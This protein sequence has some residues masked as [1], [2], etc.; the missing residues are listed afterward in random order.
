MVIFFRYWNELDSNRKRDN[1]LSC[2]SMQDVK[3]NDVFHV[4][5]R[6]CT[7]S[8]YVAFVNVHLKVCR[9]CILNTMNTSSKKLYSK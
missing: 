9:I 1:L 5:N 7:Y 2:M 4:N 8:N 6:S 3:R